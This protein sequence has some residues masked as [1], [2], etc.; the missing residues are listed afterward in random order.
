M[1]ADSAFPGCVDVMLRVGL[2]PPRL[3]MG[4]IQGHCSQGCIQKRAAKMVTG[5]Q[6]KP[7]EELLRALSL[8]SL[9][10]SEGR[11]HHTLQL[12]PKGQWRDKTMTS[13]L[14]DQ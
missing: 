8:F 10:E 12:P 9:E 13:A 2:G 1:A 5:L 7:Y 6:G 4:C 3:K 14:S 11:H